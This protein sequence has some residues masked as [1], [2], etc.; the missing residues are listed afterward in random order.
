[1]QEFEKHLQVK[2]VSHPNILYLP[3]AGI[4]MLN[5]KKS[6]P[7]TIHNGSMSKENITKVYTCTLMSAKYLGLHGT[8]T[9]NFNLAQLGK[10]IDECYNCISQGLQY[11]PMIVQVYV[12]RINEMM[13]SIIKHHMITNHCCI[14]LTDARRPTDNDD[15]FQGT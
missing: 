14:Q 10:C 15:G 6:W 13:L 4:P 7:R 1:M 9:W 5:S 3:E 11:K 12:M 8:L 2:Q